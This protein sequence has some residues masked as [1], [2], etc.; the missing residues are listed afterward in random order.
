MLLLLPL[1]LA[2]LKPLGPK[3]GQT[4]VLWVL[5]MV[6][7]L[8]VDVDVDDVKAELDTT[9][10]WM[11]SPSWIPRLARVTSPGVEDASIVF[12]GKPNFMSKAT[13]AES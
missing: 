5:A 9:T 8:V 7:T 13:C 4:C 6:G 12:G 3:V 11:A 10:T 1:L 2:E